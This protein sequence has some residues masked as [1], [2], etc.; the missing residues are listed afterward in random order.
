MGEITVEEPKT[1]VDEVTRYECDRCG[2]VGEKDEMNIFS[3]QRSYSR[4]DD[5]ES[6]HLCDECVEAERYVT[7]MDLQRDKQRIGEA[8]SWGLNRTGFLVGAAVSTGMYLGYQFVISIASPRIITE[9]GVIDM[10]GFV[11]MSSISA[12]AV[13]L[14]FIIVGL[15]SE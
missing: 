1:V 8:I 14:I 9:W 3:L 11:G 6:G 15:F 5:K 13:A 7:Y 4:H 12:I 2:Y 10:M